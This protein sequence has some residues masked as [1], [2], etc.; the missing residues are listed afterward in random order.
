MFGAS[1]GHADVLNGNGKLI[2]NRAVKE[3]RSNYFTQL[4]AANPHN[5]KLLFKTIRSLI[6]CSPG[7]DE[8]SSIERCVIPTIFS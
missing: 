5:P 2:F 1:E 3:E 4:I 6:H 7:I 8:V